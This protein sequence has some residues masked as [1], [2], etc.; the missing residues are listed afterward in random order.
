MTNFKNYVGDFFYCL[1]LGFLIYR[2]IS[3]WSGFKQCDRPLNIWL[4]VTLGFYVL[5]RVFLFSMNSIENPNYFKY[6]L[7]VYLALI[8]PAFAYWTIH[9]TIWIAEEGTN[10]KCF[11]N[12]AG[13]WLI[14]LCLGLSYVLIITIMT[15]TI[16]ETVH[17]YRM[18]RIRRR[19]EDILNN[20][21]ILLASNNLQN[22]LGNSNNGNFAR[23]ELGLTESERAYLKPILLNQENLEELKTQ[24]CSICI[25]HLNENDYIVIL[26][27]CKHSFHSICIQS[28]L[29]R[30][31]FCPN[32]KGNIRDH[33]LEIKKEEN[34]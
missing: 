34:V 4:L 19:I 32:C 27:G 28:W 21:D 17:F 31:P 1:F 13:F 18:I 26:P 20:I 30:K 11:E 9:G 10:H 12:F 29:E 16:Y 14:Y 7:S 2:I 6:F 24:D 5:K 33:I 25:E 22:L 23:N 3:S 15:Y 8:Y